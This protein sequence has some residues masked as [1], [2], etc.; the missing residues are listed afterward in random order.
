MAVAKTLSQPQHNNHNLEE[1]G[2]VLDNERTVRPIAKRTLA[3]GQE[4]DQNDCTYYVTPG[5]LL[6]F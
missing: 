6:T 5:I 3:T 2:R 4:G 1:T